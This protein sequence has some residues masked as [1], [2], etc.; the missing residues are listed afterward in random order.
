MHLKKTPNTK[1]RIRLS[2]VDTYYDKEKK[3]SRQKTIES[4]GWLDEL[5]KQYED[6]IA[7]FSKRVEQ[8]REEKK[9]KQAPINFTFYDS[10]RLCPGDNLRKNFGYAALSKIYH[11]LKIDTFLINRQRHSKE[12]YDAN[13]IMKMLVYSRLLSPM[14]KKASFDNREMFFEKTNYSL[15]D[16][17]RRLGFLNNHKENLQVWL[18]DKIK[19]R[20]RYQPDLLR[21]DEL[22]L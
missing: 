10:D 5:E 21:C 12:K 6:P 13:T 9:N 2:I 19:L 20:Q 18:N 17:Y 7:H 22:L 3:T 1:G 15:D 4:L 11:E 14:S 8:L 16:V